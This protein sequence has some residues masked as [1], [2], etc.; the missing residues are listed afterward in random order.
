VSQAGGT[1][2]PF[3]SPERSRLGGLRGFD[4]RADDTTSPVD[5]PRC[6]PERLALRTPVKSANSTRSASVVFR[7]LRQASTRPCTSS[8][9]SQRSPFCGSFSM[10]ISGTSAMSFP[11]LRLAEQMTKHRE[12]TVDPRAA[13]PSR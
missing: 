10:S 9:M 8:V 7:L 12:R 2:F 5:V 4:L 11:S 3:K 13:Q 1:T 6:E